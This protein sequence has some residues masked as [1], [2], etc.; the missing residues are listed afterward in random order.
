MGGDQPGSVRRWFYEELLVFRSDCER[1]VKCVC[2]C[3]GKVASVS[4][5]K[6][7]V[8]GEARAVRLL[9]GMRGAG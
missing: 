1:D 6:P 2:A 7:R 8:F 4:A 3:R 9:T 5:V